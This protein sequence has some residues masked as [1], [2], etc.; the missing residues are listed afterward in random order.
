MG[1]AG[2]MLAAALF[3]LIDDKDGFLNKINSLLDEVKVSAQKTQKCAVSGTLMNVSI[4]GQ[5]ESEN[6]VEQNAH[7][8]CGL[9]PQSPTMDEIA[10]QARNDDKHQYHSHHHSG[11]ADIE[12]ILSAFP[13]SQKAK[14]N[15]LSIY[16]ILAEAESKV[17]D[18][19]VEQIHFHEVGQKDA[20]ADITAVCLLM[21]MLDCDEIISS[22]INVGSGFVHCAH[23][24]LPVPAP[25]TALILQGI[26]IYNNQIKGEL[27]TPTG[28]AIIKRFAKSFGDIPLMTIEKIG[29]GMGKKDFDI[30]NCVR[31]FLGNTAADN[32]AAN[33]EIAQLSCNL[34]DMTGEAIGFASDILL[35]EGA[36]D[37]FTIP[38]YMKKNR[39]ASLF[40]CLCRKEK[41]DFF[42]SLILKHTS[43]FGIRKTICQR[44]ILDREIS[45]IESPIGKMKV[46]IGHGYGV[47]KSKVEYEDIA[48]AALSK[49]ISIKEAE[50]AI[51]N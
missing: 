28:A 1:A 19:P 24:I 6:Q 8:H 27:C 13:I 14:D 37:V 44:Y 15:V 29:Y 40:V 26:P 7:R 33:D 9:D 11:F 51:I 32:T 20:I 34:D 25:A 21:E 30:A 50:K 36:L 12:K 16:K 46:K 48:K 47:K 43:T 3:E 39:P 22:P 18:R 49:G 41:A 23:G 17:H 42:A 5:E 10:G 45:E 35:K 38:I 31:V 2:D 4:D